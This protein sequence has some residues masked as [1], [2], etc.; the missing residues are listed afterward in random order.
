MTFSVLK[1]P[2]AVLD[3]SINWAP[4]LGTDTISTST[5]IVSG[6][7]SAM[8]VD[9]DSESTTVTTVWLS[10]GTLGLSYTVTNRVV[11]TAG[12]TDDRSIGFSLRSK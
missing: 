5:W 1:D 4:W 9:S 12:R 3:Y 10:G 6:P 8:V 7:D 2:D 11:T